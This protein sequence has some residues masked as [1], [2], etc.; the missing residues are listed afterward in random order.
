[1]TATM[2]GE[3]ASAGSLA[4]ARSALHALDHVRQLDKLV[5]PGEHLSEDQ[6][7]ATY[8]GIPKPAR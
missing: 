2:V 4:L 6:S 7:V 1:M 8:A 5:P 3:L